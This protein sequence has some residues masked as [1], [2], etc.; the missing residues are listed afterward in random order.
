MFCGRNGKRRPL[1]E[2]WTVFWPYT[3]LTIG[4]EDVLEMLLDYEN[5]EIANGKYLKVAFGFLIRSQSV[6]KANSKDKVE[7]YLLG[8]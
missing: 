7:L 1:V 6:S 5:P 3:I 8:G 4:K 2:D